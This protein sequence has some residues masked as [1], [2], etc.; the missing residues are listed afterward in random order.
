MAAV[1]G[2]RAASAT[3]TASTVDTVT[4]SGG[5]AKLIEVTHHGDA[6]DVIWFRTDGTN[7]VAF[8][9]ECG[10]LL[11]SERITVEVG[12]AGELRLISDGVPS[13][14]AQVLG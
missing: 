12:D 1:G 11:A 7:P 10:V 3:L 13:Y 4:L 8:A 5:G 6:S 14:T 9:D 2:T